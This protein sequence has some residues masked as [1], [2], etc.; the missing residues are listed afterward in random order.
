[1]KF[2]RQAQDDALKV[3]M[4]GDLEA[5]SPAEL[6][7]FWSGEVRG[8]PCIHLDLSDVDAS[9]AEATAV[10]IHLMEQSLR[11]GSHLVVL[12]APQI[13]AHSLYNLTAVVRSLSLGPVDIATGASVA[14]GLL[15]DAASFAV[16][17]EIGRA[18]V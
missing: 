9:D 4:S 3:T 1:M 12:Q 6:R 7:R 8:H 10:L 11:D 16:S 17:A 13:L 15:A 2:Q 5:T 14:P 18:H